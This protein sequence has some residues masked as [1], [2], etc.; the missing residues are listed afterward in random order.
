MTALR[1]TASELNLRE[2]PN[3]TARI[4]RKLPKGSRVEGIGTASDGWQRVRAGSV[5]VEGW[6]AARFLQSDAPAAFPPIPALA[7]LPAAP[8]RVILHWTGGWP[9][10]NAVDLKHYHRVTE[11][12]GRTVVGVHSIASNM[13][14]TSRGGA[15]A[16][17][18]GGFNSF[19]IGAAVAGMWNA[20]PPKNWGPH[21]ITAFQV[22]AWLHD[23]AAMCLE[24]RLDPSDPAH[25]FTHAEAWRL[26][27]VKGKQNHQKTDL[28]YL[29]FRPDLKP[30]DVGPW[31]RSETARH[32]TQL[33][34][35]AA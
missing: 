15:Y 23:V 35:E 12:S 32:L 5:P 3:A 2:S 29:P 4:V 26:H 30:D 20:S 8:R 6:C 22:D 9:T 11:Q 7:E 19:S 24:Y 27:R 1:V 18:T 17:H 25:L 21:P 13:R 10:A 28:L 34:K 14:D 33:R 31:L 16:Q